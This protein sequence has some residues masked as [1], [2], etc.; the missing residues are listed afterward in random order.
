[1]RD[2]LKDKKYFEDFLVKLENIDKKT[3]RKI[4]DGEINPERIVIVRLSMIQNLMNRMQAKYSLG[5]PVDSILEEYN[6]ALDLISQYWSG[7]CKFIGSKN[8]V[9]DQYSLGDYDTMLWMLSIGYLLNIPEDR[10]MILVNAIDKDHVKDKLFEFIISAKII[11]R[12]KINEES[13][14]YGFK[15][16]GSIRKAIDTND[17]SEAANLIKI[18]LEK[19]WFKEHKSCGWQN[20]HKNPHN[21]YSG[22]W[23]FEAAAVVKIMGLDDSSFTN[24]KYYPKDLVN[25]NNK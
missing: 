10:F 3:E 14:K 15:L 11:S 1:M 13:Y 24:N 12:A 19:E 8:E 2:T 22:F 5:L 25:S 17:L 21:T 23:C 7:N 6:E 18:F 16:F 9:L 20:R 4:A